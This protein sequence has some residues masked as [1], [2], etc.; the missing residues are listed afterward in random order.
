MSVPTADELMEQ[1]DRVLALGG[2]LLYDRFDDPDEP[3]RA[4]AD[5]SGHPFCIFVAAE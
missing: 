2:R 3:L 4:Y 5:P 1:H